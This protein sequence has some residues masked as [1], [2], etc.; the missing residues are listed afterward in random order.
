MTWLH[1]L[2]RRRQLEEQLEKELNFH[3]DQHTANL[4]ARGHPPDEA[5]RQAQ[6]ALGGRE[7]V[8]EQCRDARGTRWLEDLLQ[9]LRYALRTLAQRPGFAAVTLCTLALGIG[10]TT[11]MFTVIN[12][13]LLK[14]LSY[15]EPE[16]LITLHS[17]TEAYGDQWGISYLDFLDCKRTGH[18]LAPM[19]AWRFLPACSSIP[20][21]S[22]PPGRPSWPACATCPRCGQS[23]WPTSSPCAKVKTGSV[24]GP[25][26]S[27]RH[28]TRCRSHWHPA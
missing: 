17:L 11:V 20:R 25:P 8:K 10:A 28:P 21:G 1:R 12:G 22:A 14:P 15:P 4:I 16:R 7:Q 18:S 27:R 9:D 3:L 6:L 23:R 2:L 5:R 24:T 19:A 26:R 13:V